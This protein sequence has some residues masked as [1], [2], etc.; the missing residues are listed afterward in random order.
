[1]EFFTKLPKTPSG[2][3]IIWVV[4]DRII[5]FAHFLPIK[6]IDKFEKFTRTYLEDIVKFQGVLISIIYDRDSRL[7]SRFLEIT[8]AILENSLRHEN[9]L[10]STN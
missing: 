7:N 6:E 2:F 9:N 1:M 4:V 3:D 8:I 5:K 10:P